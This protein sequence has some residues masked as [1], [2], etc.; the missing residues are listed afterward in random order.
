MNVFLTI[1]AGVDTGPFDIYTNDDN[2]TTPIQTGIT[3]VQLVAG[4]LCTGVTNN[5]TI[6]RVKSV[7][8]CTS[9]VNANIVYPTPTPTPSPTPPPTPSPTPPPPT[10]TPT[11]YNLT[12]H[13]SKECEPECSKTSG[14][15]EVNGVEIFPWNFLTNMGIVEVTSGFTPGSVIDV[16][17]LSL[18]PP[19][20]PTGDFSSSTLVIGVYEGGPSGQ[21]VYYESTTTPPDDEGI[22]FGTTFTLNQDMYISITSTCNEP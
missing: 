19:H 6:I 9:F 12:Y 14:N 2:F 7:G 10:P 15:I 11:S 21:E 18:A 3:K 8:Y 5:A 20:C 4:Y 17:G 22:L 16:Y 1:T 13:F